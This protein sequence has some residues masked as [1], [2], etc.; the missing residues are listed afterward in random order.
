MQFIVLLVGMSISAAAGF[1]FAKDRRMMAAL[2]GAMCF[3]AACLLVLTV[4]M[5]SVDIQYRTQSLLDQR[6]SSSPVAAKAE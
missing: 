1:S 4:V 5:F 2:G 6:Q 3:L